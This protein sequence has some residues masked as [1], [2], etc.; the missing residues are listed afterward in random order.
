MTVTPVFQ[1]AYTSAATSDV[2]GNQL[3]DIL[4]TSQRNNVRDGITGVLM[5]NNGLFFQILEG[6]QSAVEGCLDRIRADVRHSAIALAFTGHVEHRV[7]ARWEMGFAGPF[8]VK[9]GPVGWFLSF[10]EL[11]ACEAAQGEGH[12]AAPLLALH[13]YRQLARRPHGAFG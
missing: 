2:T 5:Y 7:F 4:E 13:V 6:D 10:E 12:R 3:R 1:L 11:E 8:P 9:G